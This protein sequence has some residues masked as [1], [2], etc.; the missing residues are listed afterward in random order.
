M[1]GEIVQHPAPLMAPVHPHGAKALY[2]RQKIRVLERYVG[3][4]ALRAV[5]GSGKVGYQGHARPLMGLCP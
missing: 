2:R 5:V 4:D 3:H 1:Y